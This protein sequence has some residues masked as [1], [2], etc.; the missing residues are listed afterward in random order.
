MSHIIRKI[1]TFT[2]NSVI[3]KLYVPMLNVLSST[4][5]DD[6]VLQENM[7]ITIIKIF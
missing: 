7:K 6:V 3:H 2:E 1:Y 5:I 4:E